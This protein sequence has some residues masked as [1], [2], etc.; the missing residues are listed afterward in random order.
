LGLSVG[1]WVAAA[2]DDVPVPVLGL[3]DGDLVAAAR[4]V[5]HAV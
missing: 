3:G 5:A 1:L 4:P 2:S